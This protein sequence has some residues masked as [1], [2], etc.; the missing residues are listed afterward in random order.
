[1]RIKVLVSFLVLAMGMNVAFAQEDVR[2]LPFVSSDVC[3]D[4]HADIHSYWKNSMH[5]NSFN[6]PIFNTAYQKAIQLDEEAKQLCLQCHAPVVLLNQ[7]YD[8][9]HDITR[10][11]VTCDFCHTI[12][13]ISRQGD[14]FAYEFKLDRTRMGPLKEANSPIHESAYSE[15][16]TKSEFCAGC[17]EFTNSVGVKLLGTYSEWKRSPYAAEGIQCQ[18]CHMPMTEGLVVRPEVQKTTGGVNLHDLQGGHSVDKVKAAATVRIKEVQ[19][20]PGSVRISVDVTNK[21]SGHSIPTGTPSR[22][23]LLQVELLSVPE[24]R[25]IEKKETCFKKTLIGANGQ[26]L[27]GDAEIM[28]GAKKLLSDNRIGPRETRT[29]H[30]TFVNMPTDTY[31]IRVKLYYN[32]LAETSPGHM[33]QMLIEM[34]SEERA[35]FIQ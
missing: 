12:T 20:F 13:A 22:E 14:N 9:E 29:I 3:R 25:L 8:T 4:C 33:Q 15:L 28:V 24:N 2:K 31:R 30:A 19:K 16:H 18:N 32:Y 27:E 5:A 7:D 17:H 23:L 34:A 6:D 35:V 21:G 1:M 11:G 10:E 26:I